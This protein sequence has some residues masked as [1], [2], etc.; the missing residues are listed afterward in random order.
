MFY[1]VKGRNRKASMM[2]VSV[3]QSLDQLSTLSV[4]FNAIELIMTCQYSYCPFTEL[5]LGPF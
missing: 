2:M 4:R 1:D 3:T 5:L